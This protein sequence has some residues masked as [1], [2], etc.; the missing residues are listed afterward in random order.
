MPRLILVALLLSFPLRAQEPLAVSVYATAGGVLRWLVPGDQRVKAE[1]AL[2][3]LK[4]N[5]VFL[6]GR[7]G[8]E[9]VAPGQLRELRDWFRAR[10]FSVT[11]AIAT[12]P[13]KT[14]GARQSE[15]YSWLNWEAPETRSAITRFFTENAQV[16]DEIIVDDFY[17][18]ADASPASQSARG[19]RAWSEYRRDLLVSLIEPLMLRPARAAN[20]KVRLII[21]FPQW[22]DR[23]HFYGYDPPR[24][25]ALF[26]RVWVG[27]EVRNPDTPRMG[28]VQPTEGF[29]NFMWISSI[30]GAKVHG[31]WFDHIEST[32]WNFVD[33]AFQ[34]VLAG[35]RELTLFH[36]G[37]LMEP[38]PGDALLERELPE[39]ADLSARVRGLE[40]RGVAFYKP[41]SSD[42]AENQY[43]MDYLAVIGIPVLPASTYPAAARSV[44]L[45]LQAAADI[46][47][48]AKVRA[49]LN[50]GAT[51][52]LTPALLRRLPAL[53]ELA[54]V[55]AGPAFSPAAVNNFT[56]SGRTI[57]LPVAYE[58][59]SGLRAARATVL[60]S[61]PAAPVLTSMRSGN[62]RVL[63][64]NAR[65]FTEEDFAAAKE[66]LLA[67]AQRGISFLP[68]EAASA[69]RNP[70][71]EPLGLHLI[72]P[73]RIALYSW[74]GANLL[75]NFT[76]RGQEVRFNGTAYTLAP[77]AWLWS[78]TK[79][80]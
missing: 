12:V 72:S 11:G 17:C 19:A 74:K 79:L 20:P 66:L 42:A 39:L 18:T 37:D 25:S 56:V 15:G 57:A 53:A 13:G 58:L 51:L 69:L 3:R 43:L 7:R 28:F 73:A 32:G 76:S 80:Q 50:R 55:S 10:G 33:Q 35:A 61:S 44:I 24:M 23:F 16:F 68:A 77:H 40:R 45:G 22:Y 14:F 78:G 29:I 27:T 30:A 59:D 1:A 70:M 52:A 46:G 36:L 5:R 6:E 48:P 75:Y 8:D 41:P 54:G 49:H 65:T 67:P 63:V 26:D 47:L 9:Y 38:H 31:A 34:S 21:K 60:V 62:G 71:L 64:L 2:R 4:A